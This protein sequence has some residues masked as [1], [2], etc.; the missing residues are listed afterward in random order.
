MALGNEKVE[1]DGEERE[2]E[3]E[4]KE[5]VWGYENWARKIFVETDEKK[6]TSLLLERADVIML[7]ILTNVR[8]RKLPWIAY[9]KYYL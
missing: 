7:R 5:K 3:S 1:R 2:R 8:E 9:F 6:V 4:W